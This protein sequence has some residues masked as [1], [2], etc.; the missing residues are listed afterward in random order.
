MHT[1]IVSTVARKP[2]SCRSVIEWTIISR[3]PERRILRVRYI[4]S[5]N[6]EI[7]AHCIYIY[8]YIYI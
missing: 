3:T 1:A 6:C 2:R 4:Q 5:G 8:I 7:A